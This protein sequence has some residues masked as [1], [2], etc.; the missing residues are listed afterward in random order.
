VSQALRVESKSC[1][2]PALERRRRAEGRPSRRARRAAGLVASVLLASALAFHSLDVRALFSPA[3]ARYALIAREMVESGDWIQPRLNHVR[4]YEKPPLFYWAVAV[5][6]RVLGINELSARL[7]SAAAYV[8]TTA[9]TYLIAL[10]LLGS[11]AAL[12]AA[13]IYCTSVG[14]FLFGRFVFTDTLFV[15]SLSLSLLGLVRLTRGRAPSRSA[16]LFYGAA[17][18]ATLT[19]GLVGLVFPAAT[20]GAWWLFYGERRS[21]RRLRPIFGVLVTGVLVLPWHV[22]LAVRDPSFLYF[23]IVNEHIRRFL[24]TRDPIDYTPLSVLAFSLATLLWLAPWSLFLAGAVTDA[25]G[26]RR[27][28]FA[29]P[30]LWSATVLVFFALNASRLEYYALPAFPALA[31]LLAGYWQRS[32][33]R[34]RAATGLWIPLALLIPAVLLGVVAVVWW[35]GATAVLTELVANL[36]G[37]YREYFLTHSGASFPLVTESARL[38]QPFIVIILTTA[39]ASLLLLTLDRARTAFVVWAIACLPLLGLVDLG[40]RVAASDR[41]ERDFARIVSGSWRPGAHLVVAGDYED[42]C[43]VSYYTGLPT[44]ILGK[45]Q[46]DLLFGY[47][48]GDA[49]AEFLDDDEFQREWHSSARVFVVCDRRFEMPGAVVLAEGARERLI[50]NRGS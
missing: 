4:Y 3:E 39:A 29:I 18:L 24:N 12:L 37:F 30:L 8:G 11:G 14:P 42:Y 21:L 17:S 13:I 26:N 41:S 45:P 36:D 22:C 28:R 7:P 33:H 9:V 46:A 49:R 43:G 6:D 23:Y 47:R 31:V 50:S 2:A 10:E 25:I 35:G 19:K 16:A 32:F 48:Q 27:R 38:A 1:E 15:F 40:M 20:T 34:P 44:E 5:A